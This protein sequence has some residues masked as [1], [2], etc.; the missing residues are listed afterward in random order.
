MK[1]HVCNIR[2]I[3][4]KMASV[5]MTMPKKHMHF[6]DITTKLQWFG[7]VVCR[8]ETLPKTILQGTEEVDDGRRRGR[9]GTSQNLGQH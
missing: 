8:Q 2:L 5:K 6:S 1:V 4:C 9:L 7:H 3:S